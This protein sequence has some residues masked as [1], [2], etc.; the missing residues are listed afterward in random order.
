MKERDRRRKKEGGKVKEERQK[1][2]ENH[3]V[4]TALEPLSL[5]QTIHTLL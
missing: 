1:R 5:S 4:Q 2:R 3:P